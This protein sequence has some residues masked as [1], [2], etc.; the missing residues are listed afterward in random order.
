MGVW[1]S[2]A[3]LYLLAGALATVL[4]VGLYVIVFG[5]HLWSWSYLPQIAG[6]C[7]V[8]VGPAVLL[9]ALA[10]LRGRYHAWLDGTAAITLSAIAIYLWESHQPSSLYA[11]S[12][13]I[14]S[15]TG[16]LSLASTIPAFWLACLTLRHAPTLRAA[17]NGT[18]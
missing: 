6:R 3:V 2:A 15:L 10:A 12:Q 1:R 18:E 9:V 8:L 14:A 17:I 5:P 4:M 13:L 16:A 11:S 7:A